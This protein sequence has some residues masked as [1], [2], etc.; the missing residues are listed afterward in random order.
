MMTLSP[1]D[2]S[3][4]P[5][6]SSRQSSV[7]PAGLKKMVLGSFAAATLPA[8]ARPRPGTLCWSMK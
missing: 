8:L 1:V 7:R 3:I 4:V 2:A 6:G 5:D